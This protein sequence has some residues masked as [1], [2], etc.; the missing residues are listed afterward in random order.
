MLIEWPG[1]QCNFVTVRVTKTLKDGSG[2]TGV[3]AKGEKE[4]EREREREQRRGGEE[5]GEGKKRAALFH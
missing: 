2:D 3:E 5:E 1:A 4:K